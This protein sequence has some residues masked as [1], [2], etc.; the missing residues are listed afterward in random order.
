M[1]N[2]G[3]TWNHDE[4]GPYGCGYFTLPVNLSPLWLAASL[5]KSVSPVAS[6]GPALVT[7]IV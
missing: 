3:I 5:P 4:S 1:T 2:G 7:L 6:L